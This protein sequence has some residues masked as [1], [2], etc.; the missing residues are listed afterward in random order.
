MGRGAPIAFRRRLGL[1][2][3]RGALVFADFEDCAAVAAEVT[4]VAATIASRFGHP[5]QPVFEVALSAAPMANG[6]SAAVHAG[7]SR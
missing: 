2:G 3:R 4:A 7:R 5:R 1:V 6:G